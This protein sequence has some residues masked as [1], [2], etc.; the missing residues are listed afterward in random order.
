MRIEPMCASSQAAIPYS[1]L[2]HIAQ[3]VWVERYSEKGLFALLT[4]YF[5]DA[6]GED[7]GFTSVSGWVA[8]V[9]QWRE[10]GQMW[11][12]MLKVYRIP[13]FT[14]KHCAHWKGPFAE[15]KKEPKIR[16]QFLR[17]ASQI[18]KSNVLQGFASIVTHESYRK[19]NESFTLKE[20]TKSEYA[21]A[22]LT[23]AR[24]AH[25]WALK[26]HLG[27]PIEFVFHDG[28]PGQ[29]GLSD[30]IATE[31]R[32]RPIFR[33]D[34]EQDGLNPVIQLQAADFLAYEVRKIRKDDP[35]EIRPI[36]KHRKSV[37]SLVSVPSDWTHYTE[38]DLIETCNRH[39]LIEQR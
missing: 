9:E 21:L 23:C 6:G 19:V 1:P 34:K 39:P 2:E 15:W 18:I 33:W 10:F 3:S 24:H 20:Y 17:A 32:C 31:L 5:D 13:Y 28:T 36:E 38:A 22:G 27:E 14:M 29:Q 35:D 25:D 11:S 26:N 12:D 4:C 7:H 8:S 30:L 37:R 16:D